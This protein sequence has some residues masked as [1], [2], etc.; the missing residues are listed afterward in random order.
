M[1]PKTRYWGSDSD[2][3]SGLQG[4]EGAPESVRDLARDS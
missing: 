1:T 4:S 2:Q 3:R